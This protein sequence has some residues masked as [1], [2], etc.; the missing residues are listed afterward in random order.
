[1][2][3]S[4]PVEEVGEALDGKHDVCGVRAA[5]HGGRAEARRELLNVQ[6]E[7]RPEGVLRGRSE[8]RDGDDE[9]SRRLKSRPLANEVKNWT[10]STQVPCCRI[11]A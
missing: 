6:G 3:L 5:Q 4:A 10:H 7:P 11:K 9:V 2:L 8:E 1:M